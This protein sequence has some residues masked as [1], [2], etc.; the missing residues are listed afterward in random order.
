[1]FR[2]SKPAVQSLNIK[3]GTKIHVLREPKTQ[4]YYLYPSE[5]GEF[6]IRNRKE[7]EYT[8]SS[9][10]LRKI[11]LEDFGENPK[12]SIHF[13]IL[14]AVKDKELGV[15]FPLRKLDI[16]TLIKHTSQ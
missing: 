16:T 14:N 4:N 9:A 11:M 2:F 7:T 5:E 12:G 3:K 1:M 13:E 6:E 8:F 15:I 10:R